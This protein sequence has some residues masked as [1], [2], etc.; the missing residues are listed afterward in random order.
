[1][2]TELAE[3]SLGVDLTFG[4]HGEKYGIFGGIS[5]H[6]PTPLFVMLLVAAS[7]FFGTHLADGNVGI[8]LFR[9]STVRRG[10]N[11][12]GVTSP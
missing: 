9:C 7:T 2:D 1:M 4:V 12:W 11:G 8:G 10:W 5:V 3:L 6:T